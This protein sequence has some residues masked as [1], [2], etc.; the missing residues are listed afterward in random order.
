MGAWGC[1]Y[2]CGYAGTYDTAAGT[3]CAK[4]GGDAGCVG[5]G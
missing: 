3:A 2:G 1:A 4:P 5:D